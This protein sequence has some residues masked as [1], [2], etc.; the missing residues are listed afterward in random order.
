[1]NEQELQAEIASLKKLLED[2]KRQTDFKMKKYIS[3]GPD[4]LYRRID[5]ALETE[6]HGNA[7]K[8]EENLR[9]TLHRIASYPRLTQEE[10]I[11]MASKSISYWREFQ[12]PE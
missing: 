7:K 5:Q 8:I 11:E 1:M 3:Y 6:D 2:I 9:S 4:R 12:K 10:M